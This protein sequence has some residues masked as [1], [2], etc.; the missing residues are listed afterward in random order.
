MV[1][2]N[3]TNGYGYPER[4][5]MCFCDKCPKAET[6]TQHLAS[7]KLRD[8][9]VDGYAVFPTMQN[10][11]KCPYY[12][13]IRTIHAA[14]GFNTIF[15]NAKQI[16]APTLRKYIKA[17]L[18]GNGQYY[19][20]HHGERLLTPEQQEWI[21]NLFHQHGYSTNLEFDNYVDTIDW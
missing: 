20:Y 17:Y 16:D 14:Y 10:K 13:K 7:Q 8:D 19:H 2:Q 1:K 4:Y 21:I 15:R 6:C 3:D 18:G 5:V 9:D 12:K 11:D